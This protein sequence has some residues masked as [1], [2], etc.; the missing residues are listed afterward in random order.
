MPSD[1]VLGIMNYGTIANA[2]LC[3][4]VSGKEKKQGRK[5]TGK[6]ASREAVK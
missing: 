4:S 1:I 2:G 6:Q 3:H 5:T